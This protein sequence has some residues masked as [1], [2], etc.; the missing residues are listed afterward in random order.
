MCI[1]WLPW[2]LG[3]DIEHAEEESALSRTEQR[4]LHAH[5]VPPIQ[6]PM[7]YVEPSS[8]RHAGSSCLPLDHST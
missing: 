4:Q 8:T 7:A 1:L 2:P 5:S 6:N 3:C